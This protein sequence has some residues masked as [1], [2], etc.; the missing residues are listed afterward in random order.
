MAAT[1]PFQN[2]AEEYAFVL[3]NTL[4][5]DAVFNEFGYEPVS[6]YGS[7]R[8]VNPW[9][10]KQILNWV[11]RHDFYWDEV[12]GVD[13]EDNSDEQQEDSVVAQPNVV[14]PPQNVFEHNHNVVEEPR[15]VVLD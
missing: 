5:F 4:L 10:R 11:H 13:E 8:Q 2:D 15:N 14:E 3:N 12:F 6:E 9:M 7:Y 1:T